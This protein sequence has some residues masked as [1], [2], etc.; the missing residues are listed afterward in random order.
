MLLHVLFCETSDSCTSSLRIPSTRHGGSR[1]PASRPLG[2]VIAWMARGCC[3]ALLVLLLVADCLLFMHFFMRAAGH[4]GGANGAPGETDGVQDIGMF[5][6]RPWTTASHCNEQGNS[7]KVEAP[8]RSVAD[9]ESSEEKAEE[10]DEKRQCA[11]C[12]RCWAVLGQPLAVG[13][14]ESCGGPG[15]EIRGFSSSLAAT[16]LREGASER[17]VGE[18]KFATR[19][20]KSCPAGADGQVRQ[21]PDCRANAS[22]GEAHHGLQR[23]G[24]GSMASASA[25]LARRQGYNRG[26]GKLLKFIG[27]VKV[28]CGS[29]L[30]WASSCG[31]RFPSDMNS[32]SRAFEGKFSSSSGHGGEFAR[33]ATEVSSKRKSTKSLR[34]GTFELAMAVARDLELRD[35]AV[36]ELENDFWAASNKAAKLSKRKLVVDL[37]QA[38]GGPWWVPPLT[39]N[40]VLG[41]AAA[42]KAAGLKS[43]SSLMN[44][45]KLWHVEQGYDVSH[46]LARLLTLAKKSLSRNLGPIKRAVELKLSGHR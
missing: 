25:G 19:S 3:S 10:V 30:P 14:C 16:P 15:F 29:S 33:P 5:L 1:L 32:S 35:S 27:E 17:T 21:G 42:L 37:A 39:E 38:G 23:R 45:L 41:V 7:C 9:V 11:L 24:V 34:P 12:G 26:Q 31:L 46:W 44:E 36:K 40:V 28:T 22:K 18:D 43:A 8:L 2:A 4:D 20:S 6:R 13:T